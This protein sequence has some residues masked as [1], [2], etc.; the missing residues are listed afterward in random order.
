MRGMRFKRIKPRKRRLCNNT[1]PLGL[2][3]YSCDRVIPFG[4]T[5]MEVVLAEHIRRA[6]CIVCCPEV[7]DRS[8]PL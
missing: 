3:C 1:H 8:V 5:F 2:P 4:E 7:A 6:V